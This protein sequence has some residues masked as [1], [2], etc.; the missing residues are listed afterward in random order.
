MTEARIS[1]LTRD[2]LRAAGW[3]PARKVDISSYKDALEAEGYPRLQAA[4][5]FLQSFGGLEL[6]Y[7]NATANDS[8]ERIL[9]DPARAVAGV[10]FGWAQDY[11]RRLGEQLCAIGTAANGYLLLLMTGQGSVYA[12]FDDYL[13]FV[14]NRELESLDNLCCGRDIPEVG[15]H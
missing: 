1:P 14:G 3:T 9:L 7:P 15:G 8:M 5:N 12:G 2:I 10:S 11:M 6:V 4:M 13:Y